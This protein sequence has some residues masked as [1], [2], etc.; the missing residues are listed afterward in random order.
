M[1]LEVAQIPVLAGRETEFTS[2][3]DEA[4]LT[5]LAKSDGFIAFNALGWCVER[6]GVFLFTIEWETI[7]HHM[8]GFRNSEA[9]TQWRALIGPFFD[10][11]PVV[12]HFA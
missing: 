2:A 1:V 4:A 3:L 9:F 7:E 11:A 5:L 12:E 6:P 8:E 10:G